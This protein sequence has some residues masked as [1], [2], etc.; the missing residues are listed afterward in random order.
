MVS[1]FTLEKLFGARPLEFKMTN[2][3]F[4]LDIDGLSLP[5]YLWRGTLTLSNATS[6]GTFGNEITGAVNHFGNGRVVWIPTPLGLG[7]RQT[8]SYAELAKWITRQLPLGIFNK[9][10]Y[11][12]KHESGMLMKSFQIEEKYYSL[13]INKT[14]IER[15]I[16]IEGTSLKE[17]K[18]W[19]ADKAVKAAGQQITIAPEGT[20]VVCWNSI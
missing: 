15:T 17:A 12:T 11:F 3:S 10:P 19:F 9:T 18:V 6:I 4:S 16:S 5:G 14:D 2:N 1:G 13:I 8:G 20:V 7:A